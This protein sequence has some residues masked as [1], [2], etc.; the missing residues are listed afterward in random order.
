[1]HPSDITHHFTTGTLIL[2]ASSTFY[3]SYQRITTVNMKNSKAKDGSRSS[4]IPSFQIYLIYPAL[5]IKISSLVTSCECI[6]WEGFRNKRM[7]KRQHDHQ[8]PNLS[9]PAAAS[10]KL[11][12]APQAPPCSASRA[13]GQLSRTGLLFAQR[14]HHPLHS[15][16]PLTQW[17]EWPTSLG[18]WD[19][20]KEK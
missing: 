16:N 13:L 12:T 3:K 5:H 14:D 20:G 10:D 8:T 19:V 4:Q 11:L 18:L 7:S 9:N 17:R 15:G 1:M 2:Q 6:P